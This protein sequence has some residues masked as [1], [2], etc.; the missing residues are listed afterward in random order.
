[1][2]SNRLRHPFRSTFL[3]EY[4]ER[5]FDTNT[6]TESSFT[7]KSVHARNHAEHAS[8]KDTAGMENHMINS[9]FRLESFR[10]PKFA[11]MTPVVFT[12]PEI[13]PPA[14]Y[15]LLRKR[16]EITHHEEITSHGERSTSTPSFLVNFFF[17]Q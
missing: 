6:R 9:V 17:A 7:R 4:G 10:R 12:H 8:G 16:D 14:A 11:H 3:P 13:S 15:Q 1:M 2:F 5:Q